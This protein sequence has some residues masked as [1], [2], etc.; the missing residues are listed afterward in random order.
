MIAV[1]APGL[2]KPAAVA[3]RFEQRPD[4]LL[5]LDVEF[6]DYVIR[7]GSQPKAGTDAVSDPVS[8]RSPQHRKDV[9]L[10][11]AKVSVVIDAADGAIEFD[12]G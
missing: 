2:E 10:L 1:V 9:V 3:R 6:D 4:I 7:T 5:E 8:K 11:I 12:A